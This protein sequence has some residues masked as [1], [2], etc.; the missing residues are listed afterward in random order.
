MSH[1]TRFYKEIPD[2]EE[3]DQP[4]TPKPRK[5]VPI[6]R[7]VISKRTKDEFKLHDKD[8]PPY[9]RE[10][11]GAMKWTDHINQNKKVLNRL[12]EINKVVYLSKVK[13]NLH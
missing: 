6:K 8:I 12:N 10:D 7:F 13:Y 3:S 4:P 1:D 11:P 2:E 5:F 9:M